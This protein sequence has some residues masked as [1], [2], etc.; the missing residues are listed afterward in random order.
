MAV[1]QG[2]RRA[3]CLFAGSE[4]AVCCCSLLQGHRLK[5]K[6]SKLF[7]HLNDFE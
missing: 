5:S 2:D 7:L 1:H 6:E 4:L 3:I